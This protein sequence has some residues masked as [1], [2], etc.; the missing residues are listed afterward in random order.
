MPGDDIEN[1]A[2]GARDVSTSRPR[3][4][5][6]P[7]SMNMVGLPGAA[8]LVSEERAAVMGPDIRRDDIE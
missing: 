4:G 5:G 6:D 8:F 3:A 2:G 7:D 1:G